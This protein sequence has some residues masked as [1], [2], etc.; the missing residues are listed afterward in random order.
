MSARAR[1]HALNAWGMLLVTAEA[2]LFA[3]AA[4][5]SPWIYGA[6]LGAMGMAWVGLLLGMGWQR[7]GYPVVPLVSWAKSR[8]DVPFIQL[9][10]ANVALFLSLYMWLSD[11]AAAGLSGIML[12]QQVALVFLVQRQ[13]RS[14]AMREWTRELER[15]ETQS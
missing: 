13:V 7:E 8:A 2:I 1:E 11:N 10:I 12:A 6:A 5:N 14:A 9:A 4:I 3:T 15:D